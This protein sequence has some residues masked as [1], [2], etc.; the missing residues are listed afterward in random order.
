MHNKIYLPEPPFHQL[1]NVAKLS[2]DT[3]HQDMRKVLVVVFEKSDCLLP[4]DVD[5]AH[6]L[7]HN[8]FQK[9]RVFLAY[10]T[11]SN[12]VLNLLW[13][14]YFTIFPVES[15]DKMSSIF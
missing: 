2:L 11:A 15:P 12:K 4:T 5:A 13:F 1:L 7:F 10:V 14:F 8:V 3:L 9:V 6:Q